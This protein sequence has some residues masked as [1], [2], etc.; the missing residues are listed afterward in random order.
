M[1]TI[2]SDD[3]RFCD[4]N[5]ERRQEVMAESVG[6]QDSLS[7]MKQCLVELLKFNKNKEDIYEVIEMILFHTMQG[8]SQKAIVRAIAD[9]AE[10]KV[11]TAKK[12]ITRAKG[13]IKKLTS[14]NTGKYHMDTKDFEHLC[15]LFEE[16]FSEIKS[17]LNRIESEHGLFYRLSCHDE[18]YP[19]L[20]KQAFV[21]EPTNQEIA[22]KMAIQLREDGHV[23]KSIN[24][25]SVTYEAARKC[26]NKTLMARCLNG[27]AG[28]E[29]RKGNLEEAESLYFKAIAL[30][31][32]PL[33]LNLFYGNLSALES[34]KQNY[35]KSLK[36]ISEKVVP[37]LKK[38]NKTDVKKFWSAYLEDPAVANL[39]IQKE[40][41]LRALMENTMKNGLTQFF[42]K[43]FLV[44]VLLISVGFVFFQ[45]A[46]KNDRLQNFSQKNESQKSTLL[47]RLHNDI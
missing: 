21:F 25:F 43:Y 20:I 30:T 45:C 29:L 2:S 38:M 17:S 27:I 13:E 6:D 3:K 19:S 1:K 18:E 12:R 23:E 10:I 44:L 40:K 14:L 22:V 11:E 32:K 34:Q 5:L 33:F 46:L 26:R 42:R 41:E 7:E 24:L 39:K 9:K 28:G 35:E 36:Y 16:N 8:S 15:L 31:K 4:K 47:A 37:N